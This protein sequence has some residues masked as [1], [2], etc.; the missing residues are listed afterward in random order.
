MAPT[1]F[2][3][4]YLTNTDFENGGTGWSGLFGTPFSVSSTVAHCG[5][6]SGMGM[7]TQTYHGIRYDLPALAA[8][9]YTLSMWLRHDNVNAPDGGAEAGTQLGVQ[10]VCTGEAGM[11]YLNVAF[12]T[13]QPN[14][15]VRFTGTLTIPAG[16][17]SLFLQIVQNNP[18]TIPS[19]LWVDDAYLVQ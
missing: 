10:G 16:C 12:V 8:G 2:T 9:A 17:T 4:N 18:T 11:S 3:T 15:F 13:I 5:T 1:G 14:T 6:H 19:N 7:R